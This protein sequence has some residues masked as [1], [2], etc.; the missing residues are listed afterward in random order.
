MKD[1]LKMIKKIA[2]Y[3]ALTT[4]VAWGESPSLWRHDFTLGIEGQQY[5]YEE[6]E[7]FKTT[8]GKTKWM[9]QK[10]YLLG[11]YGSYRLTYRDLVFAQA[12]GRILSGKERYE[13]GLDEIRQL[14]TPRTISDMI[15]E[16]RLLIGGHLKLT[17]TIS[18]L[19]YTG[20]GYR[21]KNDDGENTVSQTGNTLAYRKS[22][23]LYLL[24]GADLELK[25]TDQWTLTLKGEYDHLIKGW[26]YSRSERCRHKFIENT[27]KGGYGLKGE[28]KMSYQMNKI[29]LF[30]T[31]YVYYWNIDK[32]DEVHGGW[33]EPANTTLESGLRVGIL[34]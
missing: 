12:E 9:N 34:F 33:N 20:L 15:A 24:L 31:P 17:P 1:S 3:T 19:P 2:L 8:Q 14:Y 25:M 13:C 29:S 26:Q 28:I 11:V 30:A 4:S 10:G 32:S 27:Q 23:Y 16:P 18:V 21:F 5:F 7:A 6:P 22:K